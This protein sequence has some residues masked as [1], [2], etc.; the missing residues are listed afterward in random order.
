MATAAIL[1]L[2]KEP[3]IDPKPPLLMILIVNPIKK[4]KKELEDERYAEFAPPTDYG[5]ASRQPRHEEAASTSS[6]TPQEQSN[7]ASAFPDSSSSSSSSFPP[8]APPFMYPPPP[9]PP[10]MYIPT[11]PYPMPPPIPPGIPYSTA[12]SNGT[13]TSV[14]TGSTGIYDSTTVDYGGT[15]S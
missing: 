9:P 13:T 10:F 12:T 5:K 15:A 6:S 14:D 2:C 7:N 11:Y 3:H 1:P 4:R 8:P